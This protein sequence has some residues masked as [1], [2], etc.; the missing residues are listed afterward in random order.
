[1]KNKEKQFSLQYQ[2][3]EAIRLDKF[4]AQELQK[5]G[6][7]RVF[8]SNLIEQGQVTVNNEV[9]TSAKK[10]LKSGDE[11]SIEIINENQPSDLVAKKID[12][13]IIY[14]DEDVIVINKPN[15]LVVHPGAGNFD[16]TLVNGLLFNMK[17][18]SSIDETRPG[19]VHRLDKQTT[20]LLIVAKN[21]QSHYFLSQELKNH[22]IKRE[23]IAL[24]H[25]KINTRSGT[26]DAPIARDK[27]NRLKMTVNQEN[28]KNAVTH[29]EVLER[30]ERYTL[31]S[32]QLETGRTH[33]I[34]VHL[35][36]INHPVVN[37]P[38]YSKYPVE[39]SNFGQY[40]HASRIT[41]IHPSTK[42]V[43]TF[44]SD[45]PDFFENRLQLLRKESGN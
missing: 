12:I 42:K 23:Y 7:S 1:M 20:G 11:V 30:F 6:Y 26:I 43:M 33:Q 38:V 8:L 25:G 15:N 28:A 22:E 9:V 27:H 16:N 13:P 39:N 2:S 37:D 40:L 34:R 17:E 35:Q 18:L 21:N 14:E 45:L 10:L 29:F 31:I 3:S 32:C 4:L 19:I 24:V 44:K 36:W 41:F 5:H